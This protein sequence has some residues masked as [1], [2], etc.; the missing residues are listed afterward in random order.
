MKK[1]KK[2]LSTGAVLEAY[3][4]SKLGKREIRK[5]KFI[6]RQVNKFPA[7]IVIG[8]GGYKTIDRYETIPVALRF[9]SNGYHA[10]ILNYSIDEDS[11]YP[12]PLLEVFESILFIRKHSDE[13]NINIDKIIL[14]GFSAGAHLAGLCGTQWNLDI[15]KELLNLDNKNLYKPNAMILCYPITSVQF[16]G[17]EFTSKW[18]KM[19][20]IE[21]DKIDVIKSINEDTVP[22][23]IWHTRTDGVVPCLQSIKLIERMTELN[24]EY[25]AHIFYDGFH[26]LSTNDILTNYK[27]SIQDGY[28]P[29]NVEKWFDLMINWLNRVIEY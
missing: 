26:G 2:I 15:F 24:I 14:I 28:R 29:V 21:D 25:E 6:D 4:L 5:N 19:L 10:F 12:R 18:G 20:Q 23:F 16:L 8:G 27:F 1:I 3:I 11:E 17:K 9:L 13:W 22:C 7:V